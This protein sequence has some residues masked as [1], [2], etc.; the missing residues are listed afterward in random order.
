[1][2]MAHADADLLDRAVRAEHLATQPSS[3]GVDRDRAV[4]WLGNAA[5][6]GVLGEAANAVAAHLALRPVRI[7][8]PHTQVGSLRRQGQNQ[9]VAADAEVPVAHRD[10]D[11]L[12]RLIERA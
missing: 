8:H 2:G 11:L 4:V 12:P 10:G 7:E 5:L 3:A 1:M 9:T 6:D